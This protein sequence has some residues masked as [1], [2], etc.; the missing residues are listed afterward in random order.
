MSI[1]KS[2]R[3]QLDNQGH[4]ILP[5]EI[6]NQYGL[7]PGSTSRLETSEQGLVLTRSSSSLA[8]V[9]IEPTNA[10]NLDC[11]ICMRNVW[12]EHVGKMTRHTFDRVMQGIQSINPSPTIFF[13]G[14]GEP[15]AHPC[16]REMVSAA[17]KVAMEV[18]LITNGTL[19]D[20]NTAQWMVESGLSRVWVSID[21]ATPQSYADVRLGD[22]LPL[23]IANLK[24]LQSLRARTDSSLPKL[25][26]AFVAMKRNIAGLPD[27]VRMG[28]KLGAD[29]FSIT[30]VLPHTAELNKEVLYN[31]SMVNNTLRPSQWTPEVALPRMDPDRLNI[32][33]IARAMKG[34][35]LLQISRQSLKFGV[36]TCPFIEKGS[37]SIRWDGE[38]SPCLPLLH[39]HE[40]YLGKNLRTSHAF[41][42]GNIQH[43]SL[44]DLWN[45]PHYLHLRERLQSF[46]FSPCTYC[47]SCEMAEANLEDCYG[48]TQPACGGCL[49]AQGFIQCP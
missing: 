39:T 1:F 19:L 18:E 15:L 9:Y 42:V 25:G 37:I 41:T 40:S 12:D 35:N 46:D 4:L 17:C 14:I 16:I 22:A 32:E 29:R 36:D 33:F 44:L 8:K 11:S 10:C 38:V 27:V 21:G 49:W 28:K 43:R 34:Q 48:N 7:V 45:D 5:E 31:L 24:R 6:L 26:I 20:E 3:I 13:G 23:V 30:N 47:N 2:I